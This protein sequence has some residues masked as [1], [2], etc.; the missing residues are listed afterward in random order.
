MS[1]ADALTLRNAQV[2]LASGHSVTLRRPSALDFIE[3]A[4]VASKSPSRL[5]AW[6]AYRHLLDESGRPVFAS[7]EAALDADG[8]LILQIGRACEQLYEEG[9]D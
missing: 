9:R 2:T 3:G 6:L 7:V 1:I 5:Y 4:D 8:L